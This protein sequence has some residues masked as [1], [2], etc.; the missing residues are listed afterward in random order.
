MSGS[1]SRKRHRQTLAVEGDSCA[2]R[3]L[4]QFNTVS[5]SLTAGDFVLKGKAS[6]R[7]K[8]TDFMWSKLFRSQES[9]PQRRYQLVADG[10]VD[11]SNLDHDLC[12]RL[13]Q[14]LLKDYGDALEC[15]EEWK[16]KC[17]QLQ[18]EMEQ[19]LLVQQE[20]NELKQH[21]RTQIENTRYSIEDF[22][23]VCDMMNRFY[24]AQ[25]SS[26]DDFML[27]IGD[28]VF[29]EHNSG[30]DNG[31]VMPH[32]PITPYD[33]GD[34]GHATVA[35]SDFVEYDESLIF[36]VEEVKWYDEDHEGVHPIKVQPTEEHTTDRDGNPIEEGMYFLQKDLVRAIN[37]CVPESMKKNDLSDLITVDKKNNRH[38]K[39]F[40]IPKSMLLKYHWFCN[41][42]DDEGWLKDFLAFAT[43]YAPKGVS[44]CHSF[45]VQEICDKLEAQLQK[46]REPKKVEW[47]D[48]LRILRF[49][50]NRV[51][52]A[53]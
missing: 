32:M 31:P 47:L 3:L 29:D 9:C 28:R 19:L 2:H 30:E 48:K 39:K 51:T 18:T 49:S 33:E 45:H 17:G 41:D 34:R 20:L 6:H 1:E 13:L 23:S 50:L 22:E 5:S 36:R 44:F 35:E 8:W 26:M 24:R 16:A 7:K 27:I 12:N 40:N 52:Q 53:T 38:I 14:S 43:K 11:S 21:I 15:A 4:E 37:S 42:T 25:K 46:R 10:A